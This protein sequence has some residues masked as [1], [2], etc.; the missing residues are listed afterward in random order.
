MPQFIK[1]KKHLRRRT[2]RAMAIITLQMESYQIEVSFG[3]EK[4]LQKLCWW[5]RTNT[6]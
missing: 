5:E 2:S 1:T 3:I 6:V 4:P